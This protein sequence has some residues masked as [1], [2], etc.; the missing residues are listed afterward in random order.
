VA[1]DGGAANANGPGVKSGGGVINKNSMRAVDV[2]NSS[3]ITIRGWQMNA[4]GADGTPDWLGFNTSTNNWFV[5][6]AASGEERMS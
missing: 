1:L 6:T 3:K 4:N 2:E 5:G